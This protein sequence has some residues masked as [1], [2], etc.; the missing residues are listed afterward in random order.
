MF[1]YEGTDAPWVVGSGRPQDNAFW[2]NT[3]IGGRESI[4]LTVADGTRFINNTFEGVKVLR[5]EDSMETLMLGNTGLE[6]IELKVND[7]SC[8]NRTSD[9]VY[10]PICYDGVIFP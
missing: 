9:A 2:N 8:F 6:G 5:F 4:K 3:I 7:G 10:G 1:T